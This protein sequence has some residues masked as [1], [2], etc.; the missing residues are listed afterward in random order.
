MGIARAAM[1]FTP[2]NHRH[3]LDAYLAEIALLW[4]EPARGGGV[5][6]EFAE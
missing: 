3:F 5:K 4:L 2:M 1:L 6:T